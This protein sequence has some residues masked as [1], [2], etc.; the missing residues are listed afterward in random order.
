MATRD[1]RNFLFRFRCNPVVSRIRPLVT[2]G[3]R[4]AITFSTSMAAPSSVEVQ[5]ILDAEP[6]LS[7]EIRDLLTDLATIDGD[8][9]LLQDWVEA[10]P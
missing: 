8:A 2:I 9:A 7:A 6:D 10:H 3:S 1:L 5:R 4:D